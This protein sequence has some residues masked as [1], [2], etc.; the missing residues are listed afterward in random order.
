MFSCCWYQSFKHAYSEDWPRQREAQPAA[1][2]LAKGEEAGQGFGLGLGAAQESTADSQNGWSQLL[3]P[4]NLPHI[5]IVSWL[6]LPV[7]ARGFGQ[8]EN[9]VSDSESGTLAAPPEVPIHQASSLQGRKKTLFLKKSKQVYFHK[10]IS[11]V[12][13]YSWLPAHSFTA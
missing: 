8:M 9:L 6:W 11:P 4:P 10:R 3:G 7:H 13:F 1:L 2:E 5:L 12:I